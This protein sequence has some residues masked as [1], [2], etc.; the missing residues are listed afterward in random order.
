M[1]IFISGGSKNGKSHYAQDLAAKLAASEGEPLYYVA[2]MIPVDDEDAL[3]IERH[4]EDRAG[5]GFITIEQPRE[6]EK[7]ASAAEAANVAGTMIAAEAAKAAGATNVAGAGKGCFLLDS[8]TALLA[9][10]M[11]R[12]GEMDSG[13]VR[14]VEDGLTE[15]LNLVP[16]AVIVSDGLFSNAAIFDG[17]TNDFIAGLGRLQQSLCRKCDV[18][19]ESIYGVN[20]IH[21]GKE[22][23][24]ELVER[25]Q[26][27]E[28]AEVPGNSEGAETVRAASAM[29]YKE[30][31][32]GGAFQGKSEYAAEKYGFSEE[33]IFSFD[34]EKEFDFTKKCYTHIELYVLCCIRKRIT[35]NLSF[36]QGAVLISDDISCGIVPM[37]KEMRL[38]REET[39]RFLT[40]LSGLS[41][42]VTRVYGG[43]AVT[44]KES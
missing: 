17:A 13:A 21:K 9:N 41:K 39:G 36:P 23:Y 42:S 19:L 20:V 4:I 24:S 27:L 3:R 15:F 18:A 2:T 5:M 6:I 16:D 35:P 43:I 22:I 30:F 34:L 26:T 8:V 40:K 11:F 1:H 10:E 33:D 14:R 29:Q 37:D 31:I 7:A 44:I 28:D 25:G 38:W 12:G 32:S